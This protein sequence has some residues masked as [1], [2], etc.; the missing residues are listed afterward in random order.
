MIK[1]GL[2]AKKTWQVDRQH[3]ASSFGGG[4]VDVLATPAGMQVAVRA[5]LVPRE[6]PLIGKDFSLGDFFPT[7]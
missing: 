3:L 7:F 6:D 4:L 1:P 5:E 2:T